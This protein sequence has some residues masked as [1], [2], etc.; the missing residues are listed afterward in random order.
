MKKFTKG[1]A[2]ALL[3]SVGFS[4]YAQKHVHGQGELHIVQE[5]SL[6]QVQ[7]IIPAVDALGFE[8]QAANSSQKKTISVLA[9]QLKDSSRTIDIKGNCILKSAENSLSHNLDLHDHEQSDEHKHDHHNIEVNYHFNCD[10][11]IAGFSVTLFSLMPSL[12]MLYVQWINNTGQGAVEVT[13]N[14][15]FINLPS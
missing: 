2:F 9:K 14:N 11:Q 12:N 15:P 13:R 3:L 5:G 6:L 7:F 4:V 8:H 1:L 10:T